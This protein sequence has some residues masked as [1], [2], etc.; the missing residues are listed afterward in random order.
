MDQLLPQRERI[1][2][3]LR[4][5]ITG[6]V[7]SDDIALQLYASDASVYE[8]KPLALVRPR[9]AADVAAC[10]QYAAEKHIPVH[11]RGAGSG[12][13]GESLGP[14]LVLDFSRFLRRILR[15]EGELVC[16]QPGMVHERLTAQL[17]L[18]GRLFGPDPANSAVTTVGSMIARDASGSR[19]LKYGSVR[20]HVRSLQV[21]LA[22]G[23]LLEFDR[24]PLVQG[25][26]ED[27]NL[28]KRDLVNRLVALLTQHAGLIRQRQPK[29]P[30][31]RC[32]YNLADV[33]TADH[34]DLAGL[35]AGSEGTLALITE[36]T[37]ATQPLPR[38]CAVV[39][40]LFE[41][42]EKASRAVGE[43][44][45]TQPSACDLMDRRHLT[46]A[47]EGEIRFHLLIPAETEAL[48]LVEY[49]G[50]DPR[51]VRDRVHRLVDDICQQR[52]LAFGVRQA[53]DQEE[54]DLFWRL[55]HKTQPLL[56]RVKGP[57]RPVPVVE[58]VA[59]PPE[60]LSAFLVRMQNVLKRNQITASLLCHAGHGQLHIQPFLDLDDPA[61][62]QRMRQAAEELYQEVFDAGGTI[63][64]E[65]AYGFSR[66]PFLARQIGPL[67]DVLRQVKQIFD[68]GNILNP[69]K[70]V[71]DDPELLTRYLRP[72]LAAAPPPPPQPEEAGSPKL[73]DLIE[74]QLDWDPSRV[75]E[76]TATCNRCGECRS[77]SPQVRM[78]P[79]FRFAPAEE[80]SPR[81]K[82]NMI[83][84]FATRSI[85]LSRLTS[86]EFK[87]VA[88]LCYHCHCC[89]LECPAGVD[90]PRLMRE[91]KGAYVAANGLRPS[92]WLMTRLDLLASLASRVS[93]LA[94]WALGNRQMRWLMEKTLGIAQGRK[95]PR[96]S[97]R[98][99]LR[100]AA[101]RRLTRLARRSPQKVLYFVDTYANYHDPQL[102]E[103][104][105]AVMKHNGVA[106]YVPAEQRPAGM[107]SI[108]CGALDHARRL[109]RRNVAVLAEA[110]RQGY[111]VVATEP[112]AALCLVHEYP[113]LLDDDDARLVAAHASEA[114]T[115]LWKM[116]NLGTLQLDLRPINAVLG[117]HPPC[118]LKA[119][120]VGFPGVN[121]LSLIPGLRVV[122]IERGCSGMAGTFGLLHKNYRSSLRAGWGLIS[123]LRD[124]ALQ[125]GVTECSACKIQMEQ[126][127]S[128]PTLH[129]IKLLALSYGLMPELAALL[130][131]PGEELLVV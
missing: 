27:P 15:F 23:Q 47:R 126:G 37:L 53:F 72:A 81:A 118:H 131:T 18:R 114:C 71:G 33:L 90:I 123:R 25:V 104:L 73:R 119:L 4:G 100:R 1:Q 55:A 102:G 48:L 32:G 127:T 78:C 54:T 93:P 46:V 42:L 60:G 52:R 35:L 80:A 105:V 109:A 112:A 75:N 21:A 103:A 49:E 12:V 86:D 88:D 111:H 113:Q 51:E 77:Q 84:G 76:V 115:F 130:T 22:D 68:P 58:D 92:D 83:R 31:S 99:F 96:V 63:G 59:V 24:A 107:A 28:R 16:V 3:D 65:H 85:D 108:A 69:G 121:L 110:V 91:S 8:I 56:Y 20:R 98:S 125:A 87:D 74:L 41:G 38:H 45:P 97:S 116:H 129:P 39:L 36:A 43:I 17:R 19:W 9:C 14:G 30:L 128:K 13:A 29:G 124:T 66:T 94:N 101:R 5:L 79:L 122:H 7:R 50:D 10:L 64:G 26:S 70:I 106:V 44:L 120:G 40:L 82:A 67:Y 2:D 95:L 61:D 117:Y 11:A 57:S 62:V 89:R 34:L 6:E